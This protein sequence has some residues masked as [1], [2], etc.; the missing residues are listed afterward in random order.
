MHVSLTARSWLAS[1]LAYKLFCTAGSSTH[2]GT[3]R[4]RSGMRPAHACRNL[5]K[6]CTCEAGSREPTVTRAL[7][8]MHENN[9]HT[10][11][12]NQ[13]QIS[14]VPHPSNDHHPMRRHCNVCEGW[15]VNS[16]NIAMT[17]QEFASTEFVYVCTEQ[18]LGWI[19]PMT[20]SIKAH[21]Q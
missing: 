14:V 1:T 15:N 17:N 12:F 6:S 13:C 2:A 20:A 11:R 18:C 9:E 8:D 16:K 21:L 10:L 5:L 7:D 4:T 19:L 3:A